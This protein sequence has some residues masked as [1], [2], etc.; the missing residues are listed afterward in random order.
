MGWEPL[1]LPNVSLA[2]A[3]REK[4]ATEGKER[5][6]LERWMSRGMF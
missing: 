2:P 3:A 5:R 6:V 4:D 1:T